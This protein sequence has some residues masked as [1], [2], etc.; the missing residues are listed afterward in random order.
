MHF[1]IQ[2]H[3]DTSN[4]FIIGDFNFVDQPIDRPNGLN[5]FDHKVL[6]LW[7]QATVG[8]SFADPYR[9]LYPRRKLYSFHMRGRHSNSRID[10]VY[11]NTANL[12]HVQQYRYFP[13]PFLDHKVQSL[14][15]RT[16]L[17]YGAGSWKMNVSLITD[18]WYAVGLRLL[19]AQMDDLPIQ[20][21]ISWWEVFLLSVRSYTIQYSSHKRRGETRLS[22]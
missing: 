14:T 17:H 15:Y 3:T 19:L 22:T 5:Y 7:H 21:A 4:S 1:L 12:P 16:I 20:D 13:T 11:V 10:R 6:P 8:L 2:Q 9:T 18:D